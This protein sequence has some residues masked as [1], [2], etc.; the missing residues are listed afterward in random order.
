MNRGCLGDFIAM[1]SEKDEEFL[2]HWIFH[3]IYRP[4]GLQTEFSK[5]RLYPKFLVNSLFFDRF[6]VLLFG[7]D[8]LH[9]GHLAPNSL[10]SLDVH[11]KSLPESLKSGLLG[12][13]LFKL[14]LAGA[15]FPYFRLKIA[16]QI[17]LFCES[18]VYILQI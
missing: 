11:M 12:F 3:L 9:A 2:I 4:I 7:T 8:L 16:E 5:L 13:L 1:N 14:H 15:H 6:L 10:E 18:T 17:A